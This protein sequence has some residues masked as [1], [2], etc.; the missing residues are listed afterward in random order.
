[1]MAID[2]AFVQYLTEYGY[3]PRSSRHSDFLSEI[4]IVDL[5]EQ[6][7]L[8][9]E[10]ARRGELVVRLR[11]HQQVGYA[12]WVIDIAFGTCAGNPLPPRNDQ[13]IIFTEPAIIQI[14]IELKSILTEHGKARRNRLRD[15]GAFHAY[16]HQ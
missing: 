6:C 7:P 16:A 2:D 4:I 14:A 10:R 9:K 3:H 15:F 11:H 12:D 13:V 5:V 1:M 8:V